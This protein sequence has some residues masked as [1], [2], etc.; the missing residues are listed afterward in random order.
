VVSHWPMVLGILVAVE[1][2]HRAVLRTLGSWRGGGLESQ[3]LAR[4]SVQWS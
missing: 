3:V 4:G 1:Q 2:A